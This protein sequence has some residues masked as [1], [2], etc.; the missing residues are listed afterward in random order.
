MNVLVRWAVFATWLAGM[1]SICIAQNANRQT[2]QSGYTLQ[3]HVREV[4]TDVTVTDRYGNPIHGLS[5]SAF[6]ILD[7]GKPQRIATFEEHTGAEPVRPLRAR[8]CL[9]Q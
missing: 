7:N 3:A 6:H 9:Q 8:E 1:A 2:P 4:I 5:E